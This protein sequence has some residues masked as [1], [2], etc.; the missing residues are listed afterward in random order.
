MFNILEF[1][2]NHIDPIFAMIIC[3]IV[4]LVGIVSYIV[5]T[6][7]SLNQTRLSTTLLNHENKEKYKTTSIGT[8]FVMIFVVFFSIGCI[9]L[10]QVDL[11]GIVLYHGFIIV[12][13]IVVCG[14]LFWAEKKKFKCGKTIKKTILVQMVIG[15][16]IYFS[17]LAL[18]EQLLKVIEGDANSNLVLFNFLISLSISL[19][20]LLQ[21]SEQ[22]KPD[23]ANYMTIKDGKIYYI[24]E[25]HN[26]CFIAGNKEDY[27]ECNNFTFIKIDSDIEL[28]GT[29]EYLI[30][31]SKRK[32]SKRKRL[33]K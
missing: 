5:K 30:S 13:N 6:I 33:K 8:F 20:L 2:L 22:I 29:E 28:L 7:S 18:L 12:I 23:K 15:I 32:K 24:F 14:T 9:T 3:I 16:L 10:F 21:F 19:L 17:Y 4:L 25:T 1:F 11:L 31:D 26:D 27:E